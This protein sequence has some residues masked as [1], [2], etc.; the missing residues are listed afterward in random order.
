MSNSKAAK[1][2]DL[3]DRSEHNIKFRGIP[4]TVT[5]LFLYD[6]LYQLLCKL[7]QD[8]KEWEPITDRAHCIPNSAFL[9][10][11]TQHNIIV[12][13]HFYHIKEKAMRTA[14]NKPPLSDKF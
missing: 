8:A 5:Q 3:E 1:L 11:Q 4:E 7:D 13:I 2:A 14:R 9:P 6:F 10:E 12:R